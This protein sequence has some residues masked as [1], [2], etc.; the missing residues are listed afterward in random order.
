[1]RDVNPS[2]SIIPFSSGAN[3]GPI[4]SSRLLLEEGAVSLLLR[5]ADKDPV[6]NTANETSVE[7]RNDLREFIILA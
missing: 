6:D 4:L 5:Q 3:R 7:R 1:M 2:G